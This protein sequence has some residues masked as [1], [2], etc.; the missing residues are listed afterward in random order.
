MNLQ[1]TVVKDSTNV[2]IVLR[3]VDSSTFLPEEA[4]EHNT[5][6]LN[7][8]YRREGA[9][10]ANVTPLIALS[11][12]DDAHSDGGI[13]HI[14]DGYYRFDM[15]DAAFA[16]GVE[17]FAFGGTVTGMLVYGGYIELVETN[18]TVDV[19]AIGGSTDAVT[20]LRQSLLTMVLGTVDTT[21]NGHM[22]TTTEFQCDD[23]TSTNTD[24]LVGRALGFV[25]G[26]NAGE[27]SLITAYTTVGGIAQ[28]TV[29]PAFPLAPA[30]NNSLVVW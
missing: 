25:D 15:P 21:V 7:I 10:K 5:S 14:D 1:R 9:V 17:G 19:A 12:L 24:H 29:A 2:S 8:W 22:P 6:G 28:F 13:E 27:A 11:A 3:I 18:P 20:A 30:N 26:P 4:V 16:T 23:I